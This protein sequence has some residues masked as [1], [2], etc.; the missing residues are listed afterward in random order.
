M[1]RR[2]PSFYVRVDTYWAHSSNYF[3]GPFSSRKE[4][5]EWMESSISSYESNVWSAG[6]LCGGD[7][8]YAWRMHEVLSYS[9]AKKLGMREEWGR[10]NVIDSSV[11]CSADALNDAT[12]SYQYEY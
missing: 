11:K 3:V 8:R 6:T 7:I 1:T 5:E 4:A 12:L 10:N 2:T 9:K